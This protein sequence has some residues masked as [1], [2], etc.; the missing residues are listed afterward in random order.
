[1]SSI[2]DNV[3]KMFINGKNIKIEVITKERGMWRE[4]IRE[5]TELVNKLFYE[6]KFNE[7]Q[8]LIVSFQIRLNPNDKEDKEILSLLEKLVKEKNGIED[9]NSKIAILLKNEWEKA[10]TEAKEKI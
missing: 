1:M 9:F 3:M 7:I 4:K 5:L 6:K 10:K 2:F 8:I